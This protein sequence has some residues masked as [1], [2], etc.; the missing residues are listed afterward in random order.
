MTPEVVLEFG[1]LTAESICAGPYPSQQP[2]DPAEVFFLT[3]GAP[4]RCEVDVTSRF[5]RILLKN[6]RQPLVNDTN[7]DGFVPFRFS[8]VIK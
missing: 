5:G 8:M 2:C 3:A 1:R 4:L 7:A 6:S